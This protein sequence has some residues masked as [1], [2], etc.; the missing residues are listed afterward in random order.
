MHE[1]QTCKDYNTLNKF[2][3]AARIPRCS[4]VMTNTLLLRILLLQVSILSQHGLLHHKPKRRKSLD[5]TQP[6]VQY[7]Q[8]FRGTQIL[9]GART[10]LHSLRFTL[11][12]LDC[13]SNIVANTHTM[14][15]V[16]HT[17]CA[18]PTQYFIPDATPT[19]KY[20]TNQ[21]QRRPKPS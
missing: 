10:L 21:T 1:L 9:H 7:S 3:F 11:G 12:K 8:P 2:S 20:D 17:H 13:Q 16:I 6:K 14:S 18:A 15:R 4:T 5:T 19:I